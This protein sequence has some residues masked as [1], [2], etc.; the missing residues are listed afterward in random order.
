MKKLTLLVFAILFIS[1]SDDA[2]ETISPEIVID[3]VVDEDDDLS[4][5]DVEL[6]TINI[7]I[8]DGFLNGFDMGNVYLSND[9]GEIIEEKEI[10]INS[11]ISIEIEK[12]PN[13]KYDLTIKKESTNYIDIDTF[14]NISSSDY[15]LKSKR[16]F[17]NSEDINVTMNNTG[18]PWEKINS[19]TGVFSLNAMNGGSVEW[20]TNLN[21]FQGTLYLVGL[22]PNEIQP[23]YLFAQDVLSGSNFE[24]DYLTLPFVENSVQIEFPSGADYTKINLKGFK[25]YNNLREMKNVDDT[26]LSNDT[27]FFPNNIFDNY[28]LNALLIF[29]GESQRQFEITNYGI[30]TSESFELPSFEA[31]LISSQLSDFELKT[32]SEYDFSTVTYSFFNLDISLQVSYEIHSD[33]TNQ[34]TFSKNVLIDNILNSTENIS[35]SELKYISVVLLR[36][37]EL[38]GNYNEGIEA[39][40]NENSEYPSGTRIEKIRI[41]E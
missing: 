5:E 41:F 21:L 26:E 10:V 22:S 36:N 6:L 40:I 19:G 34:L 3:D 2:M 29:N 9:L 24:V 4:E 15:L 27:Y 16:I 18:F 1:C 39:V 7:Q 38:S 20:N 28:E 17:Q 33:A 8:E 31:S 23:R 25:T 35:S 32:N 11:T 14:T 12:L 30:P 13:V 37:N